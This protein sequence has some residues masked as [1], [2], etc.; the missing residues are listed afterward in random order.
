MV[1]GMIHCCEHASSSG[2]DVGYRRSPVAVV[3][4]LV[5]AIGI[6]TL[7]TVT[8]IL[9]L[10]T[11]LAIVLLIAGAHPYWPALIPL[12]AVL[13]IWGALAMIWSRAPGGSAPYWILIVLSVVAVAAPPI[14]LF[15]FN[16]IVVRWRAEKVAKGRPY[17]I[18]EASRTNPFSYDLVRSLSDLSWEHMQ[19]RDVYGFSGPPYKG[20]FHA[21]LILDNPRQYLAWSYWSE[22][23]GAEIDP[24]DYSTIERWEITPPCETKPHFAATLHSGP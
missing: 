17:C 24:R 3:L 1:G 8:P 12:I 21:V 14:T 15:G 22:D 6:G 9:L 7:I 10:A 23:F 4:S 2:T 18:V 20:T 19:A 11:P 5:M 13:L 16:E